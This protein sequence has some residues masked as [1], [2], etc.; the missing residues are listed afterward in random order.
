MSF[1]QVQQKKTNEPVNHAMV[2]SQRPDITS[3]VPLPMVPRPVPMSVASSEPNPRPMPMPMS[4]PA[5]VP[6]PRPMSMSMISAPMVP[7]PIT[8]FNHVQ[9][10]VPQQMG[11][12]FTPNGYYQ[13]PT[14]H[15]LFV[16]PNTSIHS[17]HTVVNMFCNNNHS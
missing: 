5:P 13:N 17:N 15:P 2:N 14:Y 12:V 9:Q 11:P 4:V 1:W 3:N 10:N 6:N 8:P 16:S 7:A